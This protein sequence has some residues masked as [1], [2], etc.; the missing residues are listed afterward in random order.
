MPPCKISTRKNFRSKNTMNKKTNKKHR[1]TE[2]KINNTLYKNGYRHYKTNIDNKY[3]ITKG[4]KTVYKGY[5]TR[6][7]YPL[8]K[9]TFCDKNKSFRI[10]NIKAVRGFSGTIYRNG[11]IEPNSNITCYINANNGFNCKFK[12]FSDKGIIYA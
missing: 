12:G 6:A 5:I 11:S 2:V 7:G 4:N 1:R 10:N 8:N 9:G 3:V